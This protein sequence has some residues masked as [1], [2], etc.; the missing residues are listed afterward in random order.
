MLRTPSRFTLVCSL[1]LSL[2]L[3]VLVHAQQ[4]MKSLPVRV[5]D[6]QFDEWVTK[7]KLVK[8][9]AIAQAA[10]PDGPQEIMNVNPKP[11]GLCYWDIDRAAE[12]APSALVV[13]AGTRVF[14]RIKHPRQNET[15][16]PCLSADSS[17]VFP[18]YSSMDAGESTPNIVFAKLR[19]HPIA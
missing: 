2:V 8:C 13:H 3:P 5:T 11:S 16:M 4:Y 9:R 14:V 7:H 12:L 6:A 19:L 10:Y 1:L 17:E 18:S 15:I